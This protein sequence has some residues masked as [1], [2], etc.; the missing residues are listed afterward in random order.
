MKIC[1]LCKK[2]KPFSAFHKAPQ[3]KDG[4]RGECT[5]CF[6]EL[7]RI[8][9]ARPEIKQRTKEYQ[10]CPDVREKQNA[11]RRSEKG[12]ASYKRRAAASPSFALSFALWR[13]LKRCPTE[14]P[15]THAEL[16]DMFDRQGGLCAISGIK[17]TWMNGKLSP[18][19]MSMDKIDPSLGYAKGNIRL[20]C[21]AINMFR[22]QMS[23]DQMLTMARAIVA[24]ADE[25]EPSWRGFGYSSNDHI[26][27]VN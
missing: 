11:A 23:D 8:R 7:G 3:C 5:A 27:M 18:T 16:M 15:I 9:A 22:G 10:S 25:R 20:I 4:H 14:N 1:R 12:R 13:A 2:E 24:K 26:L 6:N 21:H 19:S 17:M